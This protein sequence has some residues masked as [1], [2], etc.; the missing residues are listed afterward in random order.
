MANGFI[1]FQNGL[2]VIPQNTA[3]ASISGEISYNSGLN[4]LQFF[5]TALHTFSASD[6][7]ETLTNKTI[8]G[9]NNTLL[10]L[11]SNE[12]V[13]NIS[14]VAIAAG[15]TGQTTKTLAFDALSPLTTIGDLIGYNGT[16]NIRV[17][18]GTN[19]QILAANNSLPSGLNWITFSSATA[20]GLITNN[21]SSGSQTV[22]IGTSLFVPFLNIQSA[23]TYT[24]NTGAQLI[25][26]DQT[27]INGTLIVNGTM[28]VL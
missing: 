7:T 17:P 10:N 2:Q 3:P 5:D 11:P 24:V 25:S 8:S 15:G 21:N 20:L 1:R 13:F 12:V 22:L 4:A 16:D 6:T 18:V 23:D 9:S 14:G 26:V 28:I 19:G 27:I